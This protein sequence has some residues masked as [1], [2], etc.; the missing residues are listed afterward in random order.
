MIDALLAA[1]AKLPD[2]HVPTNAK[3]DAFLL[4]KGSRPEP[5]WHWF[6][7]SPSAPRAASK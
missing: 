7:E 2:R 6:G 4:D 3:V 5:Q 1:G